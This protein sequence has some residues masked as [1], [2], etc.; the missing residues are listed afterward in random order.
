MN[1][2]DGNEN[3]GGKEGFSIGLEALK[4]C[5]YEDHPRCRLVAI[6]DLLIKL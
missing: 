3:R 6:F 4:E 5:Q 2:V 1:H